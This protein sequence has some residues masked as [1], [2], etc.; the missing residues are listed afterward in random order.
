VG[1][2]V[3]ALSFMRI[4]LMILEAWQAKKKKKKKKKNTARYLPRNVVLALARRTPLLTCAAH[5]Q[6]KKKKTYFSQ[7]I[8]VFDV[9]SK[10]SFEA[11]ETWLGEL[12]KF[13]SGGMPAI[14]VCANKVACAL[15]YTS[16]GFQFMGP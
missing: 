11:L 6:K 16:P 12:A 13:G 5:P 2:G 14:A 4:Q 7:A 15:S 1:S 9:T 10:R 8:L 3:G